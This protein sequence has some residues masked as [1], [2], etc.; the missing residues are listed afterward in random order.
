M[1]PAVLTETIWAL[2]QEDPPTV[3]DQIVVLTTTFGQAQLAKTL[4]DGGAVSGWQRLLHTLAKNGVPVE[5]RLRFGLANDCVRLFPCP[6]GRSNLADIAST[7]DNE[8]AGD[9]IMR[10][11][12]GFTEDPSTR[13]L[14]SIAGGR[15]TM[16]ALLTSCMGLLG[17]QQDRLLHVLV[18]PPY[19]TALVPPFLF[20]EKGQRHS[21]RDGKQHPSSKARIDLID[22]PFVRMRGW[23]EGA[24]KQTPPS[25]AALVQGVQQEAP[26]PLVFPRLTFDCQHGQVLVEGG[27]PLYL[28]GSEFC[29]FLLRVKGIHSRQKIAEKMAELVG[30]TM[31]SEDPEWMHDM[32]MGGRFRLRKNDEPDR[33][34][35]SKCSEAARKKIEA[36]PLLAS[37][38]EYLLP[39]IGRPLNYPAEK[40]KV[41]GPSIFD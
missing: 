28:A 17:R 30:R 6:E 10:E 21:D 36:H 31:K 5:G 41:S 33:G 4:F 7:S 26:P 12:R 37:L 8:M 24:F 18:N 32:Q 40:I 15:K 11:L 3:P 13:V 23:Y 27:D 19:D 1:T 20:P 29:V 39:R 35:V 25:Y 22:V 38:A 16:S 34:A 2:A 9:F 14:A